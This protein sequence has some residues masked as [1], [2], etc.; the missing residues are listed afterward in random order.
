MVAL[1]GCAYDLGYLAHQGIG[2]AELLFAAQPV[3]RLLDDDDV[4]TDVKRRLAL[5]TAARLFAKDVVGLDVKQQYKKV[6]FLDAP[7]VVYVVS[8][9][10]PTELTPYTW[11]YPWVGELPYRGS[12]H[13]ADA[14]AEADDLERQG[15]DVSVRLVSTYSLLGVLPDPIL[16]SMLYRRE[17]LDIVETV[18]HELAH[19]TV[20]AP[21]QG[22]FNEG[23]ATFV[24]RQGRRQFVAEHFGPSSAVA[25]R[26]SALDDD[27]D[28]WVRA[29]QALAFDLR[30]RFA[31][32][33]NDDDVIDDKASIY[34]THQRHWQLEVAPTLFSMRLRGA[35][36]PENNAE[37][38]AVGIYS[39]KQQL[40][41]EA[42]DGCG[43]DWGC[44]FR[45]LK[46]VA[47]EADPEVALAERARTRTREV[48]LP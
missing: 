36:L 2:Q 4:S 5:A 29:V 40:Y 9:A 44:F 17:E 42:F 1:G 43:G 21:G 24:G 3:S 23:L 38:S 15:F 39:L 27:D 46:S 12:F 48:T 37:L 35:R 41:E 14:E 11:S 8:A 22:A 18:I 31:Q 30:V 6:V 45:L 7:A 16:S 32:G 26:S 34:L 33:G 28:A 47:D 25:R 13:L 20:F 19:A 10:P